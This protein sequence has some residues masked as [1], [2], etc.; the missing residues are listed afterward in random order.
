MAQNDY[1][2]VDV[3]LVGAGIILAST[4]YIAHREAVLTRN[5]ATRAPTEAKLP[6]E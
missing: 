5:A 1:E 2:T 3:V 4:F 6:G